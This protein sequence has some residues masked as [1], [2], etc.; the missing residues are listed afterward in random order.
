MIERNTHSTAVA[1]SNMANRG[2]ES[3]ASL[4]SSFQGLLGTVGVTALAM[5]SMNDAMRMESNV[6]TIRFSSDNMVDAANNINHVKESVQKF[7][8]SM[9]ESLEQFA[10]LSASMKSTNLGSEFAQN[11]FDNASMGVSVLGLNSEKTNSVFRS[12]VGMA[13]KG[14][15]SLEEMK[16]ELSEAMPNAMSIAAKSMNMT[17]SVFMKFVETGNL[18][19][20]GGGG[21]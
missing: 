11:L 4:G 1:V 14:T 3:V 13:S 6:N 7:G 5:R 8:L 10:K 17:E 20:N 19:A 18:T 9:P 21:D 12:L 16:Q 2:R 15:I